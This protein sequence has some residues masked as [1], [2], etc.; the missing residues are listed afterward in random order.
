MHIHLPKPLHG[1][2]AFVGEISVI[3]L[4][5]LIALALEQVVE[6]IHE[7]HIASEAR[8]AVRAEVRENLWWLEYRGQRQ[9]CISKR[10]AQ[11]DDLLARARQGESIPVVQHLGLLG[12]AK[13]TRLR[14][15]ANSEAGRAS[16]FSGDEQRMLGNMYFTTE[17]FWEAQQQEE[18]AWSKMRFIQGLNQLTPVDVH[19]LSVLLAEA[20]YQNFIVRLSLYRAHQWAQRLHLAAYNPGLVDNPGSVAMINPAQVQIC[21]PL[22][23]PL[24]PSSDF[25]GPDAYAD[26]SDMP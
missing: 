18:I 21:Q 22:T 1:W 3:V 12:H 7:D 20:R 14:W 19:E 11:L 8:E 10:L 5:V 9:P 4:G 26:A 16:L 6:A 17:Q 25:S 2:R 24:V 23:A 15:E 13:I